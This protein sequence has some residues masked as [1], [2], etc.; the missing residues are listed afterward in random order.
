MSNPRPIEP[1]KLLPVN[2]TKLERDV[3][4]ANPITSEANDLI[5]RLGAIKYIDTPDSFLPW[6]ILENGLIWAREYFPTDRATL[7][8][9]LDI[10]QIK[11]TKA[12]V[13]SIFAWFNHTNASARTAD[14]ALLHFAEFEVD[15]GEVIT[16][17]AEIAQIYRAMQYVIPVRNRFVRLFHGYD[18]PILY[19]SEGKTE[20]CFLNA[21]SGIPY[22]G[23]KL[24]KETTG[25]F[26]SFGRNYV[27]DLS[28]IEHII[29]DYR[30]TER[31][32]RHTGQRDPEFPV[33]S[34]DFEGWFYT[35]RYF[36]IEG[37]S[38]CSTVEVLQPVATWDEMTWESF[39]W[40]QLF[41]VDQHLTNN[42]E[43]ILT[44]DN[45]AIQLDSEIFTWDNN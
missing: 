42:Q 39:A 3:L 43:S 4:K 12:A 41:I 28:E 33:L 6:L 7:I 36:A 2:A 40:N 38:R 32:Y 31:F 29:Q 5:A 44:F 13:A 26:I 22:D 18:K 45:F 17:L 9:G 35:P 10:N 1:W 21:P 23:L 19:L 30:F 34:Q 27:D 24:S 8:A 20:D 37:Q 11:G 25:L 16:N 14:R 15:T